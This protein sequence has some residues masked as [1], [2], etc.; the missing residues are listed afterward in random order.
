MGTP[1]TMLQPCEASQK[2]AALTSG[3]MNRFPP[4]SHE[5]VPQTSRSY[6]SLK[7]RCPIH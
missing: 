4:M 3:L 6:L 7:E 5:L 2:L 1:A